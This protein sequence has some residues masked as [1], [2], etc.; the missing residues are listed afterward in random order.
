[1]SADQEST[2]DVELLEKTIEEG[3]KQVLEAG[4]LESV[5]RLESEL[6]GRKSA[7]AD[8][9]QRLRHVPAEERPA[10]GRRIQELRQRAEAA[11]AQRRRE[12]EAAEASRKE[13]E[14]RVDVSLPASGF[15]VGSEHILERV[16]REIVDIFIGMGYRVVE[17][18]EVETDYYN[19]EALNTPRWHPARSMHDT[20]YLDTGRAEEVLLR[21]HTS[22]VQ[23]HVMEAEA[24][25][26]FVVSPGRVFRRDTLDPTHSPIFH[27][28]EGLA[29]DTNL[30]MGDLAG[31][32]EFFVR[33]YFGEGTSIKMRPSYFPFTE[34]S[35]EVAMSCF[36]CSGSGCATCKRSGWIEILGAGM[37][38]P[39]VFQAVGYDTERWQGFAFGM[40]VERIAMLRYGIPDIRL[41][42]ENDVRFLR[43]F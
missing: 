15:P 23:V 36:S 20:L 27:Q 26:L 24:P 31:T 25:P 1:M 34:P 35:V 6:V 7:L 37:V 16:T 28:I 33:A 17:G 14:E 19:F 38:D 3:I 9:T 8:A 2:I 10:L 12:L 22:P 30:T 21:T 18:R 40:G 11:L 42:Y 29:V 43:Q 32:L 5:A 13:E 39:N 41:F 4:D